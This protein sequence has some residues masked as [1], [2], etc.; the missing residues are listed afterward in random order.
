MHKSIKRYFNTFL[1]EKIKVKSFIM[2]LD[3]ISYKLLI[4]VFLSSNNL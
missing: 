2:N 1:K 3:L 4:S